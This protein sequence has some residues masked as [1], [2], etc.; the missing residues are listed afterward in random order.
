MGFV[1]NTQQELN[2]ITWYRNE[3]KRF[4]RINY[5]ELASLETHIFNKLFEKII[6]YY[7]LE[8]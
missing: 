5:P 1:L 2:I 6:K 7:E 4:K 3:N 8:K